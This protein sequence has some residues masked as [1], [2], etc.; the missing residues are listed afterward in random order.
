MTLTTTTPQA[1][2]TA[3]I[4][5]GPTP[6]LDL[7][8]PAAVAAYRSLAAALPGTAVHY[9][10]KANPDPVLLRVLH[11]AGARF[12]VASPAEVRA[13]L[14]AGARPEDLV[15]SN[16]VVA[17]A[18]LEEMTRLGVRLVV[19]DSPQAVVKVAATA[20]DASVLCRLVTSGE[21][22][23]WPLSRKYGVCVAEAVEVLTL[24][25]QLGLDAAGV[26]FHVGSQQNDP[27]AWQQPIAAAAR[28]FGALRGRGIHPR[29]LD[30]GGGF[31]ARLS[32]QEPDVR[33]YGQVIRSAL[34]AVFGDDVPR[35]IVE[36]GRG[37]VA[38]AGVLVSTVV[39]VVERGGTRWVFL[40]A[41][42]FTG[43]VETLDEAIRYPVTTN[44]DG[45]TTGPCVL[46]GPTCDSVDVLYQQVQLPLDLA[47]GDEVRLHGAGAYTTCYS[48]VGFNGFPPLP[49]VLLGDGRW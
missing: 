30:L 14:A 31:P 15:L 11:L 44:R 5:T 47:E 39:D 20:P 40:D 34:T 13:C 1:P 43:L 27:T 37:I 10:V 33:S 45:G 25:D 19:V 42:V 38:D 35:T 48:T 32:G 29:I 9:A 41:G 28:V 16:P 3:T 21:G 23:D 4:P 18:H 6:R 36:P 17:R 2:A 26:S 49:T 22:S 12:D 46:A 24:A 8:V 7:D